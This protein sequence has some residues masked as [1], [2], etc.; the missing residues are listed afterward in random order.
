MVFLV[1][2]SS[3]DCIS[4]AECNRLTTALGP[5]VLALFDG[6]WLDSG[7]LAVFLLATLT[8]CGGAINRLGK[9]LEISTQELLNRSK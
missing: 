9:L 4:R 2:F 7:P 3:P 6:R 8:G 1:R 5:F